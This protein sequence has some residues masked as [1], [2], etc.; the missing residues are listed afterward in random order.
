MFLFSTH[1]EFMK[2]QA[3]CIDDS[4]GMS[5]IQSV[6]N[7]LWQGSFLFMA[8]NLRRR[9]LLVP[10]AVWYLSFNDLVQ[11]DDFAYSRFLDNLID[12]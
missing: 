8:I 6:I 12:F 11:S 4:D 7:I 10:M 2:D 1:R 9:P 3:G 5:K